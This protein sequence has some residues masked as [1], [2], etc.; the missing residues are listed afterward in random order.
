MLSTTHSHP[1]N[2]LQQIQVRM[3]R[4]MSRI[5]AKHD[6]Y[7]SLALSIDDICVEEMEIIIEIL[8]ESRKMFF[9]TRNF[10]FAERLAL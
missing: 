2:S 1:S 3:K 4:R 7:S 6:L 9:K 5:S 8:M 10:D